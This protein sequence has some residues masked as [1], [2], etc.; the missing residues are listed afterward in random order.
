MSKLGADLS[1]VSNRAQAKYLQ[2]IGERFKYYVSSVHVEFL[3]VST[4][5]FPPLQCWCCIVMCAIFMMFSAGTVLYSWYSHS[6]PL[7]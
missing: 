3:Y 6:V 2:K 1:A 7:G 4:S 5:I